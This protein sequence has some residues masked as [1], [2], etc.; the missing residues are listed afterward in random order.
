MEDRQNKKGSGESP[1]PLVSL[2][3][4][5]GI[6]TRDPNL[7]NALTRVNIILG[8]TVFYS[9]KSFVAMAYDSY[10]YLSKPLQNPQKPI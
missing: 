4:E 6:R 5:D 3:A 9:I 1:E 10:F 2:G 8:I 7:G